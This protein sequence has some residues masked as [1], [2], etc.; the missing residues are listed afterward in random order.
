MSAGLFFSRFNSCKLF[1]LLFKK[2]NQKRKICPVL[3]LARDDEGEM[4]KN[5]IGLLFPC[6]QYIMKQ[7]NM[8]QFFSS[9]FCSKYDYLVCCQFFFY[10]VCLLLFKKIL[11]GKGGKIKFLQPSLQLKILFYLCIVL[12]KKD[13]LNLTAV[14]M[15]R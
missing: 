7:I 8:I 2:L 1:G 9:E 10:V 15:N 12:K 11:S 13:W 3:N 14:Q 5:K 6:T 4:D